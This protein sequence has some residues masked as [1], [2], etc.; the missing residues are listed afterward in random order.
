MT[1]A[2]I[3]LEWYVAAMPSLKIWTFRFLYLLTFKFNWPHCFCFPDFS[4]LF[5]K[6]IVTMECQ[7][8]IKVSDIHI[9]I[10][11]LTNSH[12]HIKM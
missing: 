12:T 4:H 9:Y 1:S 6:I 11:M 3:S 10:Q 5:H 8:G 2:W 7:N